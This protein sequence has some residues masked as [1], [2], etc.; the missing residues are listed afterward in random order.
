MLGKEEKNEYAR[1]E[2]DKEKGEGNDEEGM[3]VLITSAS[4]L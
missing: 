4:H 2:M 3:L 1:E